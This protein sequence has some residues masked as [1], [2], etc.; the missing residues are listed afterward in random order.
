MVQPDLR[1][2]GFSRFMTMLIVLLLIHHMWYF[3]FEIF[4]LMNVLRLLMRILF[5]TA[6]SLLIITI[7]HALFSAAPKRG[8]R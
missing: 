3:T 4:N 1:T 7:V 8:L 2:I 5:S 6:A